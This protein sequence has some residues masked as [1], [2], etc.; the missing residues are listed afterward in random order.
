M[1]LR[2]APAP[3][4]AKLQTLM[5]LLT[6]LYYN[7]A[8]CVLFDVGLE[9][10]FQPAKSAIRTSKRQVVTNTLWTLTYTTQQL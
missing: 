8:K 6:S 1:T 10:Q 7:R 9:L 2:I 4:Y 3:V 5:L